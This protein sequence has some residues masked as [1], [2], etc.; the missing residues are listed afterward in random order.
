[1]NTSTV[2]EEIDGLVVNLTGPLFRDRIRNVRQLIS[3]VSS[4]IVSLFLHLKFL[5]TYQIAFT[6][7]NNL[8]GYITDFLNDTATLVRLLYS[9]KLDMMK[10]HSLFLSQ[11]WYVLIL[12]IETEVG[13]CRPLSTIYSEIYDFACQEAVDGLVRMLQSI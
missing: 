11:L 10:G 13:N 3:N 9:H 2:V 6:S 5:S 7:L 8:K 12:Q 4:C 1:M